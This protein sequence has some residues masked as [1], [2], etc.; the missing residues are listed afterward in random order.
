MTDEF[1]IPPEQ[2]V[3][4][5]SIWLAAANGAIESWV[6]RRGTRRELTELFVALMLGGVSRVAGR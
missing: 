1:G 3:T 6:A 4:V 2:A 5:A